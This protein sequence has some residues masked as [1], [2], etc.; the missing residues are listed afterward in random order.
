MTTFLVP[1]SLPVRLPS[2]AARVEDWKGPQGAAWAR[3]NPTTVHDLDAT[4]IKRFGVT[5]TALNEE[6]LQDIPRDA[7]VLE[8]GCSAGCQLDAL[9]AIGFTDLHGVDLS[10]DAVAMCRWPAKVGDGLRLP[11][12][13]RSFDMVMTSGTFMQI[14]PH[15]KQAFMAEMQRVAR[16][17]IYGCE[18]WTEREVAWDFA[19]LMPPAWTF[20]WFKHLPRA[21]WP[22]VRQRKVLGVE[23]IAPLAFYL[24]ERPT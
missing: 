17:W 21:G 10:P 19:D 14:A 3:R 13:D 16:R 23:Q 24:L 7:S 9:A 6:M 18:L 22:I 11:Y 1:T 20:D 5:R 2:L 12:D 15:Q 8:V 4:Y